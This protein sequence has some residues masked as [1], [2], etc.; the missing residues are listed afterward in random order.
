MYLS[1][2]VWYCMLLF[3]TKISGNFVQLYIHCSEYEHP[4]AQ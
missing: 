4:Y 2:L 3:N 1:G